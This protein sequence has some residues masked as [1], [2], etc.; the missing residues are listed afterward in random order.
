MELTVHDWEFPTI[1]VLVCVPFFLF[2][3][4]LM[5][6]RGMDAMRKL[7]KWLG[8]WTEKLPGFAPPGRDGLGRAWRSDGWPQYARAS[9][10]PPFDMFEKRN[11]EADVTSRR[12][13]RAKTIDPATTTRN[14]QI[15]S[16]EKQRKRSRTW[17]FGANAPGGLAPQD[18]EPVDLRRVSVPKDQESART[19]CITV[20]DGEPSKA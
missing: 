6:K 12:K 5:T 14:A 13:R 7:N 3:L 2:V 9:P 1:M 8:R 18:V 10:Q 15:D 4:L 11:E 19:I 16:S 20:D 17:I